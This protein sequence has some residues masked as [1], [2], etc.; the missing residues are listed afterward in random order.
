M[1]LEEE[2][3]C[4]GYN[5]GY[6]KGFEQGKEFQ[7]QK[8]MDEFLDDYKE[9]WRKVIDLN[10]KRNMN[11]DSHIEYNDIFDTSIKKWEKR[12]KP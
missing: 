3:Y 8:D 7:E 6:T 5:Q 2:A 12:L 11:G 10:L 1:T 4:K 9:D